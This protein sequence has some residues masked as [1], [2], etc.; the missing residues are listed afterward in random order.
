MLRF[1]LLSIPTS[2]PVSSVKAYFTYSYF[3][4]ALS[5]SLTTLVFFNLITFESLSSFFIL[6]FLKL[7]ISFLHNIQFNEFFVPLI[8]KNLFRF[9]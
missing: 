9:Y 5:Y 7:V 2:L 4:I 8:E 6:T 3:I 1:Y